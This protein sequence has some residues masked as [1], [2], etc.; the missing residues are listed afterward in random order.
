MLTFTEYNIYE[1]QKETMSNRNN[2]NG[3]WL[4]AQLIML[5]VTL[6]TVL[7]KMAYRALKKGRKQKKD[8]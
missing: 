3:G 7:I 4:V 6:A 5:P 8:V 2:Y 1:E